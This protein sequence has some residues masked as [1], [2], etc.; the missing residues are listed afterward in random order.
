M[1]WRAHAAYKLPSVMTNSKTN[2]R[3]RL[4]NAFFGLGLMLFMGPALAVGFGELEVDSYLN[5]P[6]A[7]TIELL[8]AGDVS[9]LSVTMAGPTRYQRMDISPPRN[10]AGFSASLT[11]RDGSQVVRITSRQPVT[12]LVVDL[13]L[14]MNADDLSLIHI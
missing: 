3:T 13:V 5:Q 4:L 8:N 1:L 14:I 11:L 9:D 10:L 12:D 6:F 2:L 7:A